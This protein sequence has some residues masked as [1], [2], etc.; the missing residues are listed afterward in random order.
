MRLL[1]YFML[2]IETTIGVHGSMRQGV[3][4]HSLLSRARLKGD[5]KWPELVSIGLVFLSRCISLMKYPKVQ[6]FITH[7]EIFEELCRR[8]SYV[9]I[10]NIIISFPHPHITR[11]CS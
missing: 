1:K 6:H 8:N 11:Q 9:F 2:P 3:S 10:I 4:L 5:V 7:N